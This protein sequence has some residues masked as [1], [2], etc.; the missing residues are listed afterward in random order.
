VPL[1]SPGP[2]HFFEQLSTLVCSL[3]VCFSVFAFQDLLADSSGWNIGREAKV[4]SN[5]V[6]DRSLAF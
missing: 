5:R 2:I 4:P 3:G 6:A 1:L